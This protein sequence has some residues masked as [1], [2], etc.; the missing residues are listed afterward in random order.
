[1]NK[2]DVVSLWLQSFI[3]DVKEEPSSTICFDKEGLVEELE[4]QI[5]ILKGD[6]AL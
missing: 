2:L 4:E 5:K 1:M 3:D 6:T